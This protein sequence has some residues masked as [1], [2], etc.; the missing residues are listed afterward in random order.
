MLLD[1]SKPEDCLAKG[2]EMALKMDKIDIL[3]NNGGVSQRCPFEEMDFANAQQLINV[4][5]LAPIALCKSLLPLLKKSERPQIVNVSSIAG[6]V[7]VGVR[8]CYAASK[9]GLAAF[10]KSLRAELALQKV[11]VQNIYPGYVQTDI[12][13][14]AFAD[15]KGKKFGKTDSN[16]AHGMPVTLF[17]KE[18]LIAVHAGF[19]EYVCTDKSWH[20]AMIKVRNL[21]G[22]AESFAASFDYKNQ[23]QALLLQGNKDQ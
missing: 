19:T 9:F 10:S 12:S 16:I 2:N 17:C 18:M 6:L 20:H 15:L 13:K 8:S 22:A 5:T 14:N 11:E 23:M 21:F 7:G 3:I 1:L 4:N